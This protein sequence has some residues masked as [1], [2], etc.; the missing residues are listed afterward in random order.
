MGRNLELIKVD[1]D[2]RDHIPTLVQDALF[3]DGISVD[4]DTI[5]SVFDDSLEY[6][7]DSTSVMNILHT[8]YAIQMI[9]NQIASDSFEVTFY[10]VT[11]LVMMLLPEEL[12]LGTHIPLKYAAN[13]RNFGNVIT[14][15]LNNIK[16]CEDGNNYKEIANKLL[17]LFSDREWFSRANRTIGYILAIGYLFKKSGCIPVIAPDGSECDYDDIVHDID[18]M[19]LF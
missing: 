17:R 8:R 4:V 6:M 3:V 15:E 16:A 19:S 14:E 13:L 12:S 11:G 18:N 5:K 10:H 1:G 9:I 2:L 7:D